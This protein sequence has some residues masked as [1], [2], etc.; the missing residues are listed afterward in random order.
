MREEVVSPQARLAGA[1]AGFLALFALLFSAGAALD[2]WPGPPEGGF[3]GTDLAAGLAFGVALLA[4]L[5]LPRGRSL[6][7]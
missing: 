5:L 7:R 6:L 3:R 1:G 4:T 2:V